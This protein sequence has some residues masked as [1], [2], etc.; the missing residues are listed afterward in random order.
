MSGAE[1]VAR[2]RDRPVRSRIGTN[3]LAELE[4]FVDEAIAEARRDERR[5]VM[6]NVAD[7]LERDLPAYGIRAGREVRATVAYLRTEAGS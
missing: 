4:R 7:E 1:V 6:L 3:E 2:W 5:E